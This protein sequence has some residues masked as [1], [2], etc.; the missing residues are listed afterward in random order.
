NRHA[1]K[2]LYDEVRRWTKSRGNTIFH[3][4]GGVGG[5]KDSL[6]SYKAGFSAGRH[7]FHTWRV[8]TDR[9][10]YES[11]LRH[12]GVT[13]DPALIS[14]HFPPYRVP[15]RKGGEPDADR[16]HRRRPGGSVL[17]DPGQARQPGARGD[18]GR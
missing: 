1:D 18:R 16:L 12:K 2:L 8:V 3:V 10:S 11:L 9:A 5:A 17:R 14:G 15:G 4:G 7:P 6:F 13:P